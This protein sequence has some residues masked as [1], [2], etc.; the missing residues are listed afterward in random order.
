MSGKPS[1]M[2]GSGWE[3]LPELQ[4]GLGG[5]LKGLEGSGGL[6]AEVHEALP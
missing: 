1:H 6:S 3:A 2:S 5:P 4:K